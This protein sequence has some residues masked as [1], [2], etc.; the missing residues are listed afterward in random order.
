MAL[1]FF[2]MM[3]THDYSFSKAL[4]AL[5]LSLIGICLVMFIGLVFTD[6]LQQIYDFG[7][8]VYREFAYRLY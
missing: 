3:V 8:D 6:T 4:I 1:I 2:G 7:A 5:V